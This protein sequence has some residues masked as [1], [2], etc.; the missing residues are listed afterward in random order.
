MT[1]ES[2]FCARV[3]FVTAIALF[4]FS[5][6]SAY[7]DERH[8][9]KAG[10]LSSPM[11]GVP[12]H[13]GALL[14]DPLPLGWCL[15]LAQQSNPSIAVDEAAA[16]AAAHRVSPAGALEDPRFRYEAT[17]IP[18]SRRKTGYRRW[19]PGSEPR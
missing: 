11:L 2:I 8:E 4:F 18:V 14:P 6:Q 13:T 15:E 19:H 12:H 9:E 5:V 17:N 1:E 16:A 7:A 3:A 10:P